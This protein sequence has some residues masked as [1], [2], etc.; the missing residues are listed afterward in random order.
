MKVLVDTS[1]WLAAFAKPESKASLEPTEK[2]Q[3]LID[4]EQMIYLSGIVLFEVVRGFKH[5]K[6]R[7]QLI[8]QLSAFPMLDLDRS[9][10]L[11]AADLSAACRNKGIVTSTP[12]ALIAATAI[13]H[14]CHLFTTDKDFG[15]IAKAIPL[16]ILD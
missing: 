14:D 11:L 13:R 3:A 2:L 6:E 12:D 15:Q 4:S 16:K 1:V 7:Q 10:Y 9:D 5:P 8:D